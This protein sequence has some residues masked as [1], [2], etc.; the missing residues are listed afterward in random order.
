LLLEISFATSAEFIS[1][2]A[3]SVFILLGFEFRNEEA[4]V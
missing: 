2:L 1:I 4:D 3:C